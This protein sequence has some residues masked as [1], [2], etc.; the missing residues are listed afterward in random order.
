VISVVISSF[1]YRHFLPRAIESALAQT[2]AEVIVVDDGSTDGSREVIERYEGRVDAIFKGNGGQASALNAG[3]AR[4]R[5]DGVIFLDSDDAL[6]PGAA[7]LVAAAL[8]DPS[9]AKVQWPALEVDEGGAPTGRTAPAVPLS[10]GDQ[11]DRVLAAGP[12]G[13]HW[14]PTSANAWSRRVL[15]QILPM[16]EAHFR[17]C[18]DLYLAALAPL[19]GRVASLSDPLSV[20]RKHGANFSWRD[21]FSRRLRQGIERDELTMTMLARHAEQLGHAVDRRAWQPHAWW[22]Q[23]GGA[24]ADIVAV[25]PDGCSFILADEDCWA[26][27]PRIAGRTRVPFREAGGTFWGPPANDDEAIAELQRQRWRGERFF[28]MAFPHLWY[29]DHY[30]GLRDWLSR[31]ACERRRNDRVAIFE[32]A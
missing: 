13:Y 5:G 31:H 32:L 12:Y 23:I 16:P 14:P 3:F 30:L 20:W 10:G 26:S 1:N 27:G 24:V 15:E 2:G 28:V 29:L 18:P 25:V 17:T 4:C 19:H 8:A 7:E 21:D 22:H 6:L 11:R 9:V